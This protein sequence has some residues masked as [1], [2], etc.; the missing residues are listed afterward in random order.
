M[1]VLVGPYS[2]RLV[3]G[4]WPYPSPLYR[5]C[6]PHVIVSA[7][8][9][10]PTLPALALAPRK[11]SQQALKASKM[12][13]RRAKL[14]PRGGQNASRRPSWA[15]GGPQMATK[16][17]LRPLL[18]GSWG[19][20]GAVLG[21]LGPLPGP[22]GPLPGPPGP[23]LSFML[24]SRGSLFR[25]FGEVSLML[26]PG[27]FKITFFDVSICVFVCYVGSLFDHLVPFSRRPRRVCE[28]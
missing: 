13:P 14:H 15:P 19:A 2:T 12:E 17:A 10:P 11:A 27:P 20:L 23:L 21:S 25:G 1:G 8:R 18:G 6:I 3:F 28:H 26:G 24:A 4:G 5:P 9:V 22:P 16:A 7:L